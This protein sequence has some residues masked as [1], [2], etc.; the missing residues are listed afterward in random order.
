MEVAKALG[1]KMK[2]NKLTT[3][4][5]I[6]QGGDRM[7][8]ENWNNNVHAMATLLKHNGGEF[9][10]DLLTPEGRCEGFQC[11]VV[12]RNSMADWEARGA[13]TWK[14]IIFSRRRQGKS[15]HRQ[16]YKI[17]NFS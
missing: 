15:P 1:S 3:K 4:A 8:T 12:G 11:G 14:E 2:P 5:G 17:E 13:A 9:H 10:S 7:Q 6:V 16:H